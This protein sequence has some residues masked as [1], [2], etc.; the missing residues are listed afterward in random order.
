VDQ[1]YVERPR[2]YT[3]SF[4]NMQIG[5]KKPITKVMGGAKGEQEEKERK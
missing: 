3:P 2:Q 5:Y 4:E 1:L